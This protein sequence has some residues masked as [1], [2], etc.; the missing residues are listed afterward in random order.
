MSCQDDLMCQHID[1]KRSTVDNL[2]LNCPEAK[3]MGGT[4][5]C[6]SNYSHDSYALESLNNLIN[7]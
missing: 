7:L 5:S 3:C 2:V 1:E 4:C 6:G